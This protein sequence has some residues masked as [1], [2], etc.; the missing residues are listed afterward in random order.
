VTRRSHDG[1]TGT[2]QAHHGVVVALVARILLSGDSG[3]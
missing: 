1:D 3:A 2:L